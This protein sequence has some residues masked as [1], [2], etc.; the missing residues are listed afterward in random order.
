MLSSVVWEREDPDKCCYC[1]LGFKKKELFVEQKE[2]LLETRE[3]S[4]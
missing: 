3:N 4:E 1:N 2:F